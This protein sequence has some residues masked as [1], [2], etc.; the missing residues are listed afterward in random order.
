MF[1][2]TKQVAP[3]FWLKRYYLH[4]KEAYFLNNSHRSYKNVDG[5]SNFR[6]TNLIPFWKLTFWKQSIKVKAEVKVSVNVANKCKFNASILIMATH[7]SK[8]Q[9]E[10]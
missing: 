9:V 10:T 3:N 7:S 8:L 4:I 6:I 5:N 2:Y 1:F